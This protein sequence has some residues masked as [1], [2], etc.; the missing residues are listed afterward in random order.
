MR[1][2]LEKIYDRTK[3]SASVLSRGSNKSAKS[4]G[5]KRSVSVKKQRY[6]ENTISFDKK[7]NR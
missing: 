6:T 3:T 1:Q 5:K 7:I 4:G 2:S